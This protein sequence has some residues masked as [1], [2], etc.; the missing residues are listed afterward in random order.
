MNGMIRTATAVAC[1]L[2]GSVAACEDASPM[3]AWQLAL[4]FNPGEQQLHLEEKGRVVIYDHLKSS[5]IER[6]F[7]EQFDRIESMMFVSTVLTDESD[8][9]LR[10]QETGAYMVEDDGCD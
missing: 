1:L 3:R 9:P 2:Q 7:D 10:D 6:A 8:Q 4:L 5:D